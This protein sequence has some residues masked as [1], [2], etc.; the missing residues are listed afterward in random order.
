MVKLRQI[1][2]IVLI[3]A[4]M[5]VITSFGPITYFG[6]YLSYVT[7]STEENQLLN[8][9]ELSISENTTASEVTPHSKQ[10]TTPE[11][12]GASVAIPPSVAPE[13][14]PTSAPMSTIVSPSLN[15][16]K[17]NIS[18]SRDAYIAVQEQATKFEG[19]KFQVEEVHGRI[20]EKGQLVVDLDQSYF[21]CCSDFRNMCR[22][23]RN[24]TLVKS[25][26]E[27]SDTPPALLNATMD[28]NNFKNGQGNWITGIYQARV[29]AFHAGVD[30]KFQCKDGKM[31]QM[32]RLMPW[33]DKYIAASRSNRTSWP[34]GGDRL[35]E[36]TVCSRKY[37]FLRV[38]R[39]SYQ[40]QDDLRKMAVTLFG[41][42]DAIRRHPDVPID[43]EPLIPDV[44]LDDVAL[45]FRC[46]DVMGGAR[47]NDF[48][49]IRFNEYKKWIPHDTESIGILTQPFDTN[50]T[51]RVDKGRVGECRKVV[52]A[53]VDYLQDFAPNATIRIH[54]GRNETL[55]MAYAR[56]VMANYSFTSLSSFGIF[57][58][59]G[60]FGQGYFQEGNR[61]VNPFGKYI[62]AIL[63]NVHMMTADKLTTGQ[64]FHKKA[65]ELI[66]WFTNDTATWP[67]NP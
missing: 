8:A 39:M 19:A 1:V 14:P 18:W 33:F 40:I 60:T 42:R 30:F 7:E 11:N 43:A 22:I 12:A 59:V 27:M 62:P 16:T 31:S 20:N 36:E 13:S 25:L 56:I 50:M 35:N 52:Y 4:L 15:S 9:S 53:L 57:P 46:G 64:M 24:M 17:S 65:E 41:S 29:A 38:D 32:K 54:N 6:S 61:G 48:G 26:D 51:R 44:E 55:P 58:V 49:M 34:W 5:F 23:L 3:L 28:C 47:R 2:D 67:L 45:H 21:N 66:P 63:P 10:P 37:P